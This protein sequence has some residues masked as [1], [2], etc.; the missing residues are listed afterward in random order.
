MMNETKYIAF[1]FETG[2]IDP[3]KNPILTGYFAALDKNLNI[4]GDLELKIKPEAPFDVLEKDAMKVNGIDLEKHNNDPET[5]SRAEAAA[6][7]KSFLR[8]FRGKSRSKP[9]PLGHNIA[10]DV[11]FTRQLLTQEEWESNVHYGIACTSV[12]TNIL[13]DIGILPETVGNLESLVKYF[14]VQER[15]AHTAKDD[16]LMMIE[17]YDKMI[18]MLKRSIEGYGGLSFDI[19]S[20]LEK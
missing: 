14:G 11:N 16:V 20:A 18:Q 7:L 3:S 15:T 2:G 17:V 4:L 10:F 9:R 1:D 6:K 13:K 19:L 12:L 8:E 5:L